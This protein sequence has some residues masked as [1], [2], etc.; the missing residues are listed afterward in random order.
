MRSKPGWI[1]VSFP[2]RYAETD[3]M[4]IVHHSNYLIWFEAARVSLAMEAKI[5]K[6]W[7][8]KNDIQLLVISCECEFLESARFGDT[9][10]VRAELV[11]AEGAKLEIRYEVYRK[12]GMTL[13]AKG[14]TVNAILSSEGKLCTKMPVEIGERIKEFLV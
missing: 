9:I 5:I 1:E 11:P 13:L 7:F 8:D 14:K 3:A 6:R 2:V 4:G 12:I 10:V